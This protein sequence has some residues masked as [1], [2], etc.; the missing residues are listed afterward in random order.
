[1]VGK[2]HRTWLF[3]RTRS[4]F[5]LFYALQF[6]VRIWCLDHHQCNF[7]L[8]PVASCRAPVSS[9]LS[10]SMA[11]VLFSPFHLVEV[12]PNRHWHTQWHHLRTFIIQL[13][14]H[15]KHFKQVFVQIQKYSTAPGYWLEKRRKIATDPLHF[16]ILSS[17]FI[18]LW[19]LPAAA[20]NP[21][22]IK[23][24]ICLLSSS[25]VLASCLHGRM[26]LWAIKEKSLNIACFQKTC[27]QS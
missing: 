23:L 21:S 9:H 17:N 14:G 24:R 13:P 6:L 25:S 5:V 26:I 12:R 20:L 19:P 22:W 3:H 4:L 7:M 8:E 18:F 2:G 16:R 11:P 15:T 10:R 1:M 27:M